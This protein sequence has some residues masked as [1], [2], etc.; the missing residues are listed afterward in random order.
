MRQV[1]CCRI[2]RNKS[3]RLGIPYRRALLF[4]V[5]GLIIII[6]VV[7]FIKVVAQLSRLPHQSDRCADDDIEGFNSIMNCSRRHDARVVDLSPDL[8]VSTIFWLHI[9]KTGTSLFN[10]IFLHFCPRV[11][12]KD[13]S[14]VASPTPLMD[15]DLV[16][17][18]PPKEFC[19]VTLLNMPCP[20][21]HHPYRA[22][23]KRENPYH[24]FTMFRDPLVRLKSAFSFRARPWPHLSNLRNASI[25]FETYVN[26]SHIPNC[27]LKMVLGHRCYDDIPP[28]SLNVSLAI[29]RVRSP[30]FFFGITDRWEESICLFHAWHGGQTQ[31]FELR[32]NR[33][34]KK[35]NMSGAPSQV[36]AET[37][38]YHLVVRIFNRRLERV[39]CN[40]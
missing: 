20:G 9:E 4:I 11:T 29:Q 35:M 19:D 17:R 8:N 26:E 10:T 36:F 28:H 12:V 3:R 13:P 2:G 16:K 37:Y 21:C 32:N 5:G 22:E 6:T 25:S 24:Y 31:K 40:V 33:P 7:G 18:Y 1:G 27:Q 15:S 30:K 38:F 23:K 14:I 34:T 39:G